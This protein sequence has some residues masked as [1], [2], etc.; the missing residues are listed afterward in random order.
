[1]KHKKYNKESLQKTINESLSIREVLLKLGLRATSGNYRVFH[2]FVKNN[3]INTDNLVGPHK[4]VTGVIRTQTNDYLTNSK[5]ISSFK[6]KERLIKENIKENRCEVCGLTEW[7]NKPLSC[8]LHHI[9]GNNCNNN[10]NNLIMLCPNCH[11]Q[12]ETFSGRNKKKIKI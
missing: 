8:Q 4:S 11:S 2:R 6:L 12:T 1:M 10:I 7:Q 9:D 3:N 5:P